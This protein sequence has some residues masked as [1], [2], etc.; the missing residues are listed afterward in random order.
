MSGISGTDRIYKI[1]IAGYAKIVEP[2]FALTK[3]DCRFLWT[4]ICHLTFIALKRKLVEAPIL[5]RPNF[6]K[7]FILN[8]DWSIRGVRAILSQKAGRQEQVITYVSK[9]LSS[10]QHCFHPMEG[11]C[12]AFIWGIMYFR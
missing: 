9:G 2:L 7:S 11:E 10:I 5:V 8:V 6:N 1:F 3:K 4:P 12:Y